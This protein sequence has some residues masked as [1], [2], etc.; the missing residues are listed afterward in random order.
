V[1][2]AGPGAVNFILNHAEVD[3]VFVQDK[4]VK[5][6]RTEKKLDLLCDGVIYLTTLSQILIAMDGSD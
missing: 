3:F 6:V 2:N 5:E 1:L 4:K